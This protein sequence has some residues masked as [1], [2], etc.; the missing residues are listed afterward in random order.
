[1]YSCGEKADEVQII[2]ERFDDFLQSRYFSPQYLQTQSNL[3]FDNSISTVKLSCVSQSE[4]EWSLKNTNFT[5]KP[6]F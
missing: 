3:I 4:V 2:M 5:V 1:M 6:R